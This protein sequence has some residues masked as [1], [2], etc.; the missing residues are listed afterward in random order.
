MNL[1]TPCTSSLW[2][3]C[4]IYFA[5]YYPLS[6]L[7]ISASSDRKSWRMYLAL[8]LI[9]RELFLP[10]FYLNTN[11]SVVRNSIFQVYKY[12]FFILIHD[13]LVF[14]P[15]LPFLTS[16]HKS[17]VFPRLFKFRIKSTPPIRNFLESFDTFFALWEINIPNTV[18]LCCVF[19]FLLTKLSR[20]AVQVTQCWLRLV[21]SL[22]LYT[23]DNLP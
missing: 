11:S 15:S 10:S 22:E 6:P 5:D 3:I 19:K 17:H 13:L 4:Q 8:G 9:S 1:Q 12:C 7:S 20:I 14:F 16:L 23:W 21:F 2:I 18:G